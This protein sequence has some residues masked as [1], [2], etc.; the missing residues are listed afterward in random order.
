LNDCSCG[1][2]LKV[3][4]FGRLVAGHRDDLASTSGQP[5]HVENGIVVSLEVR[6]DGAASGDGSV[7]KQ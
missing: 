2:V 5:R 7:L 6:Q 3:P 1:G 4:E